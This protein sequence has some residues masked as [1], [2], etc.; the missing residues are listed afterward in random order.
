MH[1]RAVLRGFLP[2]CGCGLRALRK[3]IAWCCRFLA[4]L[5]NRG[6]PPR[7]TVEILPSPRSLLT[8][9]FK[10]DARAALGVP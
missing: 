1:E 2:L 7:A 3:K 4:E 9:E 10:G 5:E 8:L 6:T